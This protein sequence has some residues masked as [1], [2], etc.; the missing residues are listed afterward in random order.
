[1]SSLPGARRGPITAQDGADPI[2]TIEMELLT[3]VRNLETI[4]RKSALYRQV[5]R[6]G[7]L[8]LRTLDR[9]GPVPT[10]ALAEALNLDASTITRQVTALVA[11]GLVERVP[12]PGDRRSSDLAI[13]EPGLNVMED[14][15]RE[16]QRVLRDMFG[17]WT[18]RERRQ[19]GLSLTKLNLSLVERVAT[20]S[21]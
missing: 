19:L 4:S 1:M 12:N 6:A 13:T 8:A 20:L 5:D 16:R 14:V 15:E 17:D 9:T 21:R 18:E 2:G 10:N 11:G 7:Y 3:L